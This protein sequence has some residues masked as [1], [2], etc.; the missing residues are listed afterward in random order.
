MDEANAKVE[1]A[2]KKAQDAEA[3]EQALQAQLAEAQAQLK[4][5]VDDEKDKQPEV[6]EQRDDGEGNGAKR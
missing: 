2:E 3:R 6:D 1:E 5:K 4:A